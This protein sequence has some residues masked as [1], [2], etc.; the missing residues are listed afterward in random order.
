MKD[1][2]EAIETISIDLQECL[3]RVDAVQDFLPPV[4]RTKLGAHV[5]QCEE[6]LA[7]AAC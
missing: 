6:L 5:A 3:E 1:H 4:V 2:S 7:A